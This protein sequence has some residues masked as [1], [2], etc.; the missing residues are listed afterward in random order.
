MSTVAGF[1]MCVYGVC[2][3]PQLQMHIHEMGLIPEMVKSGGSWGCGAEDSLVILLCQ[4]GGSSVS[5]SGTTHYNLNLEDV[6]SLS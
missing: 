4:G 1:L 3:L 6:Q 2:L 5:L